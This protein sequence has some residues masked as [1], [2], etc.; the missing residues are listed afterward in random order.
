MNQ[1]LTLFNVHSRLKETVHFSFDFS[2]LFTT[3]PY[4]CLFIYCCYDDYN[5]SQKKRP[6]LRYVMKTD[7]QLNCFKL[8]NK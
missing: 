7:T 1:T 5:N 4:F 8:N 3:T 2:L 6:T